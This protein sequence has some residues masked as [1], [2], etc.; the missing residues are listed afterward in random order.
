MELKLADSIKR[1]RKERS[2]T[3]EQLAEALGVTVGAV[4]KWENGRSV[5]E[6]GMLLQLADLFE[7]SLDA[8]VGFE[9]Q[10]GSAAA[11]DERIF[12]LQRQKKYDDAITEAEKAYQVSS[13]ILGLSGITGIVVTHSLDEGL[14][15][16]YD[17]ILTLKNGEIVETGTFDELIEEKGY[18]YSLFTVSQ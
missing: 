8:L 14:L 6:I 12:E 16:Q 13:A 18:F 17:S 2:L 1:L 10:N 15:R 7:V 11:L 4:Y 5:P 9:A 3:Q